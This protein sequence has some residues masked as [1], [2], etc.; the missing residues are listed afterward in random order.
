[1]IDDFDDYHW[2]TG[3]GDD[4]QQTIQ[5][6]MPGTYTV[7]VT[8]EFGCTGEDEVEVDLYPQPNLPLPDTFSICPGSSIIINAD[9]YGDWVG[10][11]WDPGAVTSNDYEATGP[12][13][14]EL[15]VWDDNGCSTTEFFTVAETSSI[16]TG[17]AG[18]NVICTG[19]T[20]TL[21]TITGYDTYHWSPGG[22]TTSS[23]TVTSPGTYSVTVTDTQ[24]C[25]GEDAI[26]ITSGD[27]TSSINGP[28]A[29]CANVQATLN[30][31]PNGASY[32]WST[33]ETTEIIHVEE[34]T[35]GVTVT[36]AVGCVSS[37][38]ITIVEQPFVPQITGVDSICQTS[39]S[40]TLDA[41]GPYTSYQWSPNTGGATTQTITTTLPG[42]YEVTI[43]DQSGCV[44][45]AAFTVS[46]FPVPFVAVTGNP[47]FCVGGHTQLSATP[48]YPNYIWT[49]LEVTPDITINT[50][51]NYV[52]TITDSNGCTNTSSAVVNP[53]NQEEVTIAGSV[54]FCPG[55]FTTLSVP[56]GYSSV[57]WSTTETTDQIQVSTTGPVWVLVVD[58]DG[59]I[60]DDTVST[61]SSTVLTPNIVG[62]T[63]ICDSGPGNLDAGTGF[64]SYLWN[65]GLTTQTIPITAPGTYTVTVTKGSCSGTDDFVV[66]QTFSPSAVVTPAAS[67]CNVQ[68]P[69]GQPLQ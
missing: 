35:W 69:E 9:D 68:E 23:I 31:D 41:G 34:G 55:D 57:L 42:L 16:S 4:G 56:A 33:G 26:T 5:V 64:D 29:I 46:N 60:A 58:S 7:T 40:T 45:N 25:S 18:D 54:T 22:Q 17:L 48:G 52:V 21:T 53:P 43:V 10:Y 19:E 65:N 44:G 11:L 3:S 37:S 63:I 6:D 39:Q 8:N 2:S 24:G 14:F 27:F 32:V 13:D 51:G 62:P 28:T 15:T 20:I 1:M 66:T 36:N 67:A 49:S 30:A 59:C 61:L 50:P 12:G 38:S 47:D